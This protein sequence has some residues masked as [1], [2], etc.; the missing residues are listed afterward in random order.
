MKLIKLKDYTLSEV[1]QI[2]KLNIIASGLHHQT[3]IEINNKQK[4]LPF[5]KYLSYLSEY[6]WVDK[7]TS[8]QR[9]KTDLPIE[10]IYPLVENGIGCGIK[11]IKTPRMQLQPWEEWKNGYIEGFIRVTGEI[12]YFYWGYIRFK[13]LDHIIQKFH[14]DLVMWDFSIRS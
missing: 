3:Q 9:E 4:N 12:D 8:F 1:D 11:V 10:H 7:L 2:I 14:S 13:F 6:E 5:I